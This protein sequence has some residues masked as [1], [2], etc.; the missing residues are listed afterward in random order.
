MKGGMEMCAVRTV[1]DNRS[2]SYVRDESTVPEGPPL[3][4]LDGS[5][6]SCYH[7]GTTTKIGGARQRAN[8]VS[9]SD[10]NGGLVR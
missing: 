7:P 6:Q 3:R 10:A 2:C 8:A 9:G 1:C 5:L 4:R